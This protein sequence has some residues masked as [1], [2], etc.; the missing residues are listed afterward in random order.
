M[1]HNT[2]T[3][4]AVWPNQER[5]RQANPKPFPFHRTCHAASFAGGGDVK[6]APNVLRWGAE[7]VPAA[8]TAKHGP[9][10]ID[11]AT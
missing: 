2:R 1:A 9:E 3:A 7:F 10:A 5:L 6:T 4:P 11:S 8:V